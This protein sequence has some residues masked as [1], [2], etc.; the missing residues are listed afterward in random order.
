MLDGLPACLGYAELAGYSIG[1]V[2][3]GK[4]DGMAHAFEEQLA[5]PSAH[6]LSFEDRFTLLVERERAYRDERRLKRLL[7]SARL[8]Y[9]Q[10]SLED[11]DPRTRRGLDQRLITTLAHGEW[12][13]RGQSILITGRTGV[14]KTYLACALLQKACRLGKTALYVRLPRLLEEL[15]V[16]RADGSRKR[17][18]A[19]LAKLDALALND[20][21]LTA[22]EPGALRN[23]A[24]FKDWTGK[25]HLAIALARHAIH[26]G[27]RARFFS[28]V[29]LVNP[30]RSPGRSSRRPKVCAA[31]VPRLHRKT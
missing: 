25:T 11:L 8:K 28:I 31:S 22:L 16:A 26:Q 21:G 27:K 4:L 17:R 23:G 2:A 24:P 3:N 5:L 18:L 6:T 14:G 19:Q 12:L 13:T 9:A 20:W 15:K 10:A 29:D 1:P 30:Y 7:S